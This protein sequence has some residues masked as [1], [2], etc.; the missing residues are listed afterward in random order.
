MLLGSTAKSNSTRPPEVVQT[1]VYSPGKTMKEAN[2][3]DEEGDVY[4]RKQDKFYEEKD[5][6]DNSDSDAD[7]EQDD[8]VD[9]MTF[10]GFDQ[11]TDIIT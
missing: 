2:Y 7:E 1:E 8:F 11:E 3:V 5:L 9:E 10:H 4:V 6:G